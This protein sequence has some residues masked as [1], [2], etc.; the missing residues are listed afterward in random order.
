MLQVGPEGVAPGICCNC[1]MTLKPKLLFYRLI[2]F[3]CIVLS[4]DFVHFRVGTAHTA[5]PDGHGV[6][7]HCGKYVEECQSSGKASEE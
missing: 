4:V 2:S 5:Q 7:A 1:R 6:A 3:L